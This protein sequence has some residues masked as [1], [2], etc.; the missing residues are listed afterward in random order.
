VLRIVSKSFLTALDSNT[1][2]MSF[3]LHGALPGTIFSA[4]LLRGGFQVKSLQAFK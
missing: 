3:Q 1:R 2:G 4:A